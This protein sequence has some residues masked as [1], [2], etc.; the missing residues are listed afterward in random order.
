MIEYSENALCPNYMTEYIE[1]A[2]RPRPD[3]FV[4][5]ENTKT[6]KDGSELYEG[7]KGAASGG[8]NVAADGGVYGCKFHVQYC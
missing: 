7:K 2:M 5:K 3:C 4:N 8:I 6:K 1:N